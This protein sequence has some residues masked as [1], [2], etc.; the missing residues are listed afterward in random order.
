MR[1]STIP[2][3]V[4][5]WTVTAFAI[6][7]FPVH[8]IAGTTYY[9]SPSGSDSSAGSATAPWKTLGKACSTATAGTTVI[10][11]AGTYYETIQP[12][13]NGSSGNWITFKSETTGA[14]VIDGQKIRGYNV[15]LSAPRSYIRIDGFEIRN[16]TGNGIHIH[17]YYDSGAN[18][19][20]VVNCNIHDNGGDAISCRNTVGTLVENCDIHDNGLTAVAM[21]GAL[22]SHDLVVR[23][24]KIHHNIKD[25]IQGSCYNMLAENNTFY[26]QFS[27]NSHQDAF[28]IETLDGATI[29]NN[30]ISDFTQ[31]VYCSAGNGH[32][33]YWRNVYIYGNVFYNYRYWTVGGV[34]GPGGTCP[35]VTMG[36]TYTDNYLQ[37]IQIFNNTFGYLGDG[38][39]AI[40]CY[41]VSGSM[42]DT[43]KIYNNIFYNCRNSSGDAID[44]DGNV[45][46]VSADY[47]CYYVVTPKSGQDAHSI[48]VDPQFVSYSPFA[49]WNFHLKSTSPCIGRGDPNLA[50]HVTVPTPFVNMD[51]YTLSTS[52]ADDIGACGTGG[53]MTPI[54]GDIN[55]DGV[56]DA[57]DL[58]ILA[59]SWG[60][61]IGQTGY[62]SR[63][64]LN[65]DGKVD[66]VDVLIVSGN[67]GG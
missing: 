62:D 14:A 15:D 38:Q 56:V 65:G 21:G 39:K 13:N 53:Q 20:Q 31:L 42:M 58:A 26:D 19:N 67:W 46:N 55:G 28:D 29:R 66:V 60:L 54:L 64:D 1:A 5:V 18:Y 50:S 32:G 10:V 49:A 12:A 7:A 22:Y 11:K 3:T 43:I 34:S 51:G 48:Q 9:V 4:A 17:D 59:N 44:W 8:V 57:A 2:G 40:Y 63:T 30:S 61:K 24:C 6:V 25:G 35:G 27:T 41:G 36:T 47:N 45:T 37:N 33:N 23:G 52:G 16:S